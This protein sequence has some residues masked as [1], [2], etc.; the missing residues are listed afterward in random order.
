MLK[1]YFI[2]CQTQ[3]G[4]LSV[5]HYICLA[6]ENWPLIVSCMNIGDNKLLPIIGQLDIS[7][8][9]CKHSRIVNRDQLSN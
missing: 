7:C 3:L 2:F 9:M 8:E 4:K 6:A 5:S 1:I